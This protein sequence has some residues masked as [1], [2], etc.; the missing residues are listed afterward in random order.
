M[1]D[2]AGKMSEKYDIEASLGY[3][4]NSV[5]R[6]SLADLKHRLEALNIKP[7]QIPLIVWLLEEDGLT[8]SDLCRKAN[9]EQPS[10]AEMLRKMEKDGVITRVR[11]SRDRRKFRIY[12]APEIRRQAAQIYRC[13]HQSNDRAVAGLSAREIAAFVATLRRIIDN[14]R[15]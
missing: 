3:L 14:L 11:D 5:A 2:P 12:L 9:I 4:V 13:A 6:L 8:Q 15:D 7:G 1:F 10:V